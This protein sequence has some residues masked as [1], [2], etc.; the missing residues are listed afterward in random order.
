MSKVL[1][2]SEKHNIS[3]SE[4]LYNNI[5]EYCKLNE[6]KLN[7][8]VEELIQKSFNV[9]KF[10]DTPFARQDDPGPP[11]QKE[12][13]VNEYVKELEAVQKAKTEPVIVEEVKEP[14][15]VEEPA[16]IEKEEIKEKPKV[17]VEP[18]KKQE[19]QKR[20]ITRLN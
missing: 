1:F 11:L 3:I 10:G 15:P 19:N 18:P 17:E 7:V 5:K 6:L 9:E 8:F 14:E 20:K 12:P 4:R 13:V 2:M 16:P